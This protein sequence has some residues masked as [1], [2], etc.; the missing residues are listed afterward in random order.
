MGYLKKFN[1]PE[2]R[3]IHVRAKRDALCIVH[4]GYSGVEKHA[5][6]YV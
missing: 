4:F 2:V 3:V 1:N 5:A 6:L